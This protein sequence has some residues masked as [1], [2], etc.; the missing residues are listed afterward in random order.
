MSPAD[1]AAGPPAP[2]PATRIPDAVVAPGAPARPA[3][4]PAEPIVPSGGHGGLPPAVV[5]G[6]DKLLAV[7]RP[8]VLA[9]LRQIRSRRPDASPEQV[10][11]ILER[12]YLTAVTTGG[13]AVGA[14]AAI[15]AVGVGTSLA[16]SGVETAGFLEASALFAQSVTEVHG[17]ALVDPERART[18]VMTMMLGTGGQDLVRHLAAQASGVAPTRSAYW[19]ELVTRNLPG[20]AVGMVAD[21]LKRYFL[22]KFAVRQ[23]GSIV[24][25]L[26]PFGVGAVVGGAGNHL[27]A[28][29][30][31][32]AAR[33]A[34]PPP[35]ATF[36]AELQPVIRA[37]KEPKPPREPRPAKDPKSKRP[38]QEL[39]APLQK[40]PRVLTPGRWAP[41]RRALT[42]GASAPKAIEPPAEGI[43]PEPPGED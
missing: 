14:S 41:S 38:P 34:F 8:L 25:R 24:G 4:L 16:L 27:L 37:P 20:P 42:R 10:L 9:H 15:P 2:D 43:A 6:L 11:A 23:G 28:R 29:R 39:P 17:I 13:A 40:L 12:R 36:P 35:P 19:G 32:N 1:P 3:V 21:R 7:Q 18:L 26:V 30:V 31:V 22:Q 5:A 33:T